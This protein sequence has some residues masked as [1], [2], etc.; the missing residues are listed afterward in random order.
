[1][2]V[3]SV[4]PGRYHTNA[5][6]GT[7]RTGTGVQGEHGGVHAVGR[8]GGHGTP[9]FRLSRRDA[10]WSYAGAS[11]GMELYITSIMNGVRK[12]NRIDFTI[13]SPRR[14]R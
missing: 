3:G 9:R 14:P 11:R 13:D 5:P 7:R 12:W 10:G 1:M 8:G 2:R 4:P 6:E